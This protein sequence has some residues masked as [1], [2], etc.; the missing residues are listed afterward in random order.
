MPQEFFARFKR[1]LLLELDVYR[2][3]RKLKRQLSE[4]KNAASI[5]RRILICDLMVMFGGVKTQSLFAGALRLSGFEITVLL[6]K[7][8]PILEGYYRKS[9]SNVKFLYFDDFL[10]RINASEIELAVDTLFQKP[11]LTI[12]DLLNYERNGV[13]VGKNALS[14]TI[15]QLRVGKLD[16]LN[17]EH[18]SVIRSSLIYAC[19]AASAALEIVSEVN[20]E[21]AIFNERGYTPAGEVFDAC[22]I[23]G[24]G[25]IQWFGAPTEDRLLFK[26]YNLDNRS[27]HPMSLSDATWS[28]VKDMIWDDES[29]S[30]VLDR[31]HKNYKDNSAYNRQRLQDGK[32]FVSRDDLVSSLGL[33]PVKKTA[34]IFTHILYDATFFYG[35]SL[36]DDYQDWLI[37]TVRIAIS[38]PSLNWIVKVHPVNVWRSKMDGAPLEQLE[39]VALEAEFGRLPDHIK[40]MHADTDINT[41]ALFQV[42]DYGLTVR[43]TIGMELPCFGVPVVTAGTGRYSGH[44]F[45]IDP[46]TRDEF[47][48]VLSN[49][50]KIPP[51]KNSQSNLARR[52]YYATIVKRPWK[53]NSFLLDFA[54]YTYGLVDLALDCFPVQNFGE[55]GSVSEDI[56]LLSRW[57]VDDDGC[58]FI[59]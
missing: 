12:S 54:A 6:K 37:E 44:G 29:D 58:D 32:K 59:S 35:E 25:A 39:S 20:P 1:R 34:I 9:V 52:Y 45:T 53:Y 27:E 23:A 31:I 24:C 16:L 13:R 3:G 49:L 8:E 40:I 42:L 30:S 10:A 17:K 38:N 4:Q 33:D 47:Q 2:W 14:L 22:L 26:R 51:L 46:K 21:K 41:G 28:Q 56:K 55:E 36:Y 15:R 18:V 50:H 48:Y 57:I 43:G 5:G 19:T 11:A 7:K